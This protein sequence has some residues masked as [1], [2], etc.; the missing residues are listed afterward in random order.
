MGSSATSFFSNILT[1][2]TG[3]DILNP[4]P[5][6]SDR[7]RQGYYLSTSFDGQKL[8]P[9]LYY[10]LPFEFKVAVREYNSSNATKVTFSNVVCTIES[11]SFGCKDAESNA[12]QVSKVAEKI[13]HIPRSGTILSCKFCVEKGKHKVSLSTTY[14]SVTQ[15]ALRTHWVNR[16][17]WLAY[18][19]ESEA[20]KACGNPPRSKTL[21]K[22]FIL[23]DGQRQE[24]TGKPPLSVVFNSNTVPLRVGEN[25]LFSFTLYKENVGNVA[26]LSNIALTVPSAL[27]IS[28]LSQ[29]CPFRYDKPE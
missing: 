29:T 19:S 7:E 8:N 14:S 18:S 26:S 15:S 6:V 11:D 22:G 16:T 12:Q 21:D 2:A 3:G 4:P 13:H 27:N 23:H 10:S 1:Y 24:T 20:N 5:V 25:S 28:S 9:T 17:D